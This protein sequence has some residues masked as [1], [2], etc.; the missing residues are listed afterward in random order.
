L[1]SAL[2][3]AGHEVIYRRQTL[4]ELGVWRYAHALRMI[5][6]AYWVYR[7]SARLLMDRTRAAFLA[8]SRVNA[9]LVKRHPHVDAVILFTSNSGYEPPPG[10]GRP[11]LLIYT[12]YGNLLSKALAP[13]GLSLAESRVYPLWNSLERRALLMQD[14]VLVMGKLVKP[15]LEAAYNLQPEK[16]Q[17]VGAGPGLDADIE[18]DRGS[19]DPLNRTILFVGK[20]APV[21]GLAILLQAFAQ[22]R[23]AYPDATLHVV[24]AGA[25]AAPGVVP[26]SRLK[27]DEL[28]N[29]FYSCSIFAMPAFKEPLGLVFVEAMWSKC[30]CV[31][32]TTGSM[33][34]LIE[35]GVTGFLVEPGDVAALADRL[36]TLLADPQKTR[37]MGERGYAAAQRYWN[38]DA[39][40]ERMFGETG[41]R[42]D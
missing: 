35:D 32:T 36:M 11:Q 24:T 22:V 34:E 15:A 19:K 23:R 10:P 18:R 25:V 9:L 41:P 28:K 31:G 6:S 12:D 14:R 20:L 27:E 7:G 40:V 5:V 2:R 30:A 17:A 26:H 16:V 1:D 21:K 3:R 37:S 8:K 13:R 38:W 33:P 39:V 29:L 42:S 4:R